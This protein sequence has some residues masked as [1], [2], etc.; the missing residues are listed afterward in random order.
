MGRVHDLAMSSPIGLPRFA[1]A[2]KVRS[3]NSIQQAIAMIYSRHHYCLNNR[4]S[5]FKAEK[6]FN[7]PNIMEMVN[8]LQYARDPGLGIRLPALV[9]R[10]SLLQS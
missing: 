5:V 9:G 3:G 10:V 2:A 7:A 8:V 6:S 1:P 4:L